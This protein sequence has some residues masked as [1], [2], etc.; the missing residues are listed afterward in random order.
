MKKIH[1]NVFIERENKNLRVRLGGNSTVADLLRDLKLNPVSVIISRKNELILEK[2][3]L[4]DGDE[5]KILSVI[6]GG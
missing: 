2:E 5:I 4:K 1:V 6:S 3:K